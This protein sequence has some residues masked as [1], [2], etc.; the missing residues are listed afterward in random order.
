MAD[1]SKTQGIRIRGIGRYVPEMIA[2]NEDFTKIVETSDEWIT[3]RTGIKTRHITNGEP[4]YYLGAMAAKEAVADAGIDPSEIDLII[5]TT[6]T[7]DFYTPSTACIIQ[8]ELGAIGCMA[9]DINAACAGF[10][11]AVDMAKRYLHS[12]SDVKTVLVVATEELSKFT[13]YTDRSSC[14]LFGDGAGAFVLEKCDGTVYS[15]YLGADGNGADKVVARALRA[16]N[17]FRTRTEDVDMKMPQTKEHY[18][19]QDGKEVY[20]FATK[21][22]PNAVERACERA[23]ILPSELDAIVPHQANI[24]IIET[25]AKHLGLPM[26]KFPMYIDRY[27]NT[28]SASIPLAFYDAVK[29]GKIKR[30]DKVCLVG[31]GGGL[32]YGAVVF[33]Y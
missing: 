6:V 1:I 31:F 14:V 4:T 13:D 20:K 18:F 22:L 33:E 9:F 32:T 26:E 12:G 28:S 30:G 11:Y 19:Y 5:T 24:R 7:S 16:E 27:G 17:A 8:R 10:A 29:D 15:N 3:Q 21:A 2:T 23:G 25:A